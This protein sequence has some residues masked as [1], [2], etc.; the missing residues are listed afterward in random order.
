MTPDQRVL[1]DALAGLPVRIAAAASGLVDPSP[2]PAPGAWSVREV[3][4]HLAAVEVEVWHARLDSLAT[5]AH[6]EW[7]W[8]EPGPWAG[9]GAG[10]FAGALDIFTWFRT[11]TIA[12]L[13]ALDDAGWAR[14]GRH[15]TYGELDVAGLL[16]IA[17]DHD[18]EHLRQI[19]AR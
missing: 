14:G 17:V 1:R 16:R 9:P 4:L 8:V 13:D 12:R 15:A 6:P 11:A 19:A 18:E 2:A 3:I 5:E 7:S 10:S